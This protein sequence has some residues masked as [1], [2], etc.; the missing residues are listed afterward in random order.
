MNPKLYGI[1][2]VHRPNIVKEEEEEEVPPEEPK[3]EPL[4]L[5]ELLAKKQAE[6][7][8]RSKV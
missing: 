3:K 4:S 6:E 5:E 8:A 7:T 2:M 1:L